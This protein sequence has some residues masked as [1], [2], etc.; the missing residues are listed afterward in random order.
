MGYSWYVLNCAS[1]QSYVE[2]RIPNMTVFGDRTF[3]RNWTW[4]DLNLALPHPRLWENEFFVSHPICGILLRQ[5]R[6]LKQ[7]SVEDRTVF[8]V[9]CVWKIRY[10]PAEEWNWTFTFYTT[11]KKLTQNGSQT[12][13]GNI[14][15]CS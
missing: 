5:P 14:G 10:P 9:N 1:L 2:A 7:H 6:K 13:R 15:K 4:L 3:T 12:L 8:S 11:L